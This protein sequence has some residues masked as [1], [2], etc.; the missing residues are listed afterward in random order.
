VRGF[1][2]RCRSLFLTLIY[3]TTLAHW[4]VQHRPAQAGLRFVLYSL[5]I[6]GDTCTSHSVCS[7]STLLMACVQV[8]SF[9]PL[10]GRPAASGWQLVEY[11]SDG[12]HVADYCACR[13]SAHDHVQRSSSPSIRHVQRSCRAAHMA[14]SRTTTLNS[15]GDDVLGAIFLLLPLKDR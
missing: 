10:A 3:M 5:H 14:A 13:H 11:P 2:H 15:L 6:Q 1:G 12:M 9:L 8:I 7:S 4:H